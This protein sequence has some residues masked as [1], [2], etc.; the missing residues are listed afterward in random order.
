MTS[1]TALAD[2]FLRYLS[3]NRREVR[4]LSSTT[5]TAPTALIDAAQSHVFYLHGILKTGV[6]IAALQGLRPLSYPAIVTSRRNRQIIGSLCE[7]TVRVRTLFLISCCRYIGRSLSIVMGLRNKHDIVDLTVDGAHIGPYVYDACYRPD[8]PRLSLQQRIKITYLLQCHFMDRMA[9]IRHRVE[10]VLIGD[11]AYRTGML[12]ELCRTQNIKCINAINVDILQMHRYFAPTEWLRHYR[13]VPET[14]LALLPDNRLAE[15]KIAQY[16]H[17]RFG[18]EVLQH[19]AV[20]AYAPEKRTRNREELLK[21][22]GFDPALPL[23]FVMAHVLTDACHAYKP[24]LYLDYEEWVLET[25]R[26]LAQN[27][28]INF[29][30]KEHP[31]VALYREEG[32]LGRLLTRA[33]LGAH[34]AR[35]DLHTRSV[36]DHAA[37]V[38]TCGGTI[39]VE[40]AA[41]GIPVVLAAQPPYAGKGFTIEPGSRVLYEAYLR[42][43]IECSERLPPDALRRAKQ[44]AYV[45]FELFDNDANK[46]EFGGI[47]YFQGQSFDEIKFFVNVT[48]E[49]QIPW[50]HH[51]LYSILRGFLK[52]RETSII[53]YDKLREL[54]RPIPT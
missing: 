22:H 27:P 52:S 2:A 41:L 8:A 47:P 17:G 51:R 35:Q 54:N 10:L 31:S 40:A 6:M 42:S 53:N 13:D 19:D 33:G 37:A 5:R 49:N 48:A 16:F 14:T 21:E 38:V 26:V 50:E 32:I 1:T 23:V 34:L 20:R 15:E 18:G 39:G 4:K 25:A 36:L 3:S 43:G 9:L 7:R 24:T 46:L 11:P 45:M 30:V 44:V 12:F 28:R 29:L